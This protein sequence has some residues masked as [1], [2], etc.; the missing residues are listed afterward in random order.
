VGT[1]SGGPRIAGKLAA[2]AGVDYLAGKSLD[3]LMAAEA[4][5]TRDALSDA[6]RPV[7]EIVLPILDE[8]TLGALMMHFML[9]TVIIALCSNIDP[10]NQP[11]VERGK[12]F[13][14]D[15]LRHSQS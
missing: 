8:A 5:A 13:A 10:F 3:E 12:V 1:P 6:G 2:M 7:R 14:L 11:S 9:E 4:S 15:N